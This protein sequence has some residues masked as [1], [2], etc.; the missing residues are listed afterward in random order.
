MFNNL[1]STVKTLREA[2]QIVEYQINLHHK[3][4]IWMENIKDIGLDK[5]AGSMVKDVHYLEVTGCTRGTTWPR[6][7]KEQQRSKHLMGYQI[8]P[9]NHCK[10]LLFYIAL[11]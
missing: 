9:M 5:K 2:A 1:T 3:N 11:Y 7:S 4:K 10:I 6:N 8:R